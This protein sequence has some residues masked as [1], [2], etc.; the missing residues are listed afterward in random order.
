[1]DV[2]GHTYSA[3]EACHAVGTGDPAFADRHEY[4][5]RGNA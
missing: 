3:E 5:P 1:M 4:G 2:F